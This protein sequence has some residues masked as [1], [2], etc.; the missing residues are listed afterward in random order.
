MRTGVNSSIFHISGTDGT[1]FGMRI[2]DLGA[3]LLN[4]IH[5]GAPQIWTV[6]RPTEHKKLEET[7]HGFLHPSKSVGEGT[8]IAIP[9]PKFPPKC[10]NFLRHN[11]LYVPEETLKHD[12]IEYT[13]VIQ[14]LGEMVIT[15]PFAYHQAYNTGANIAESMAYASD[16]WEVFPSFR[17]PSA[18]S[19]KLLDDCNRHCSL[20][21]TTSQFDLGFV[22]SC[23]PTQLMSRPYNPGSSSSSVFSNFLSSNPPR[24]KCLDKRPWLKHGKDDWK[25]G[26][27][28]D[29]LGGS[30][31]VALHTGN[32]KAKRPKTM[33][34]SPDI[35]SDSGKL[36]VLKQNIQP[37]REEFCNHR[38]G[39]DP[40]ASSVK[41]CLPSSPYSTQ[42]KKENA[43]PNARSLIA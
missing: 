15:F 12:D 40:K 22:A 36:R 38:K 20:G 6:V 24:I 21:P 25:A 32:P 41:E 19:Q 10:D 23:P 11:P 8:G 37:V 9:R 7:L 31:P 34:T 28:H 29:E 43:R 27:S 16:R 33:A 18:P 1:V 14:Y 39:L 2:A 17:S 26:D 35:N 42:H 13:K 5:D 4:Y 3:Y 30:N